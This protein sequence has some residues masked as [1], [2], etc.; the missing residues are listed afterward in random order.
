MKPSAH[1]SGVTLLITL[2]II[3]SMM[4]L[5]G[6]LFGYVD[7]ARQKAE[8]R[9]SLIQADLL[10]TDLAGIL[11]RTLG[12]K[13]SIKTLDLAYTLP[14]YLHT[15]EAPFSLIAQCHPLLNRLRIQWLDPRYNEGPLARHHSL[16]LQVF[17]R[18]TD[19]AE[20]KN[21]GYLLEL[22]Q[23]GLGRH[24]IRFG[25]I[26]NLQKKEGIITRSELSRLLDEYRFR[27]D[28]PNVYRIRW[29]RYFTLSNPREYPKMDGEFAPPELLALILDLDRNLIRESMKPGELKNMLTS[30]G[31]ETKE[32]DWLFAKGGIPAMECSGS[33]QFQEGSQQFQFEYIGQRIVSFEIAS[34]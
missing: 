12:K 5:V 33:F 14:L 29:E 22:I 23:K 16:A 20:L 32:F 27:E 6:L 30:S 15:R 34:E 21:P 8:F 2:S 4:A 25:T 28:D 13:P 7:Q 24:S 26:D 31:V 10:R 1:R 11:R 19:Q 18:V 9:R 3:A 17:E